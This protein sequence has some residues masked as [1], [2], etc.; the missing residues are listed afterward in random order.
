MDSERASIMAATLANGGTCPLTKEKVFNKKST[1][2]ALSIMLSCGMYDYS[3]EWMFKIGVPA[4]SGVSGLILMVIPNL[5]GISIWSPPLD[6]IGNSVR[7]IKLAERLVE[8]FN[9]HNIN[10]SEHNL[11]SKDKIDF[12]EVIS[13]ITSVDI[14]HL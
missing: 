10:F 11:N 2:N 4:K 8:K 14:N 9:L 6:K 1:R 13:A 3:G 7:G 5:C 12:I